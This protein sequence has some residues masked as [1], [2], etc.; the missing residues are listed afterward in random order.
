MQRTI[1]GLTELLKQAAQLDYVLRWAKGMY[2]TGEPNAKNVSSTITHFIS[3][4]GVAID[5]STLQ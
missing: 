5:G 2:V 3:V 1:A 4:V